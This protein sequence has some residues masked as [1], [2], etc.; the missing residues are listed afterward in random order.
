MDLVDLAL[1]FGKRGEKAKWLDSKSLIKKSHFTFT[2]KSTG[3]GMQKKKK[4]V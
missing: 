2:F 1:Q 3:L 4:N